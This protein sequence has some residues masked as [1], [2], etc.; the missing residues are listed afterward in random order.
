MAKKMGCC[1][2]QIH[3]RIIAIIC[4]LLTAIS[5]LNI[6]KLIFIEYFGYTLNIFSY[7]VHDD[8]VLAIV[9]QIFIFMAHLITYVMCF[10]AA[11]R[12][13]K[14]MLIPFLIVTLLH[15]LFYI[16]LGIWVIYIGLVEVLKIIEFTKN[17]DFFGLGIL[18]FILFI[19]ILAALVISIYFLIVVAKF[20]HQIDSINPPTIIIHH[21]D[22]PQQPSEGEGEV[23]TISAPDVTPSGPITPT[24]LENVC[25]T[26]ITI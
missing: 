14:L 19:P 8:N 5:A 1:S 20:Y 18:A 4:L 17:N 16:G 11:N 25:N 7:D 3:V 10:I 21:C 24:T 26:N 2:L 22:K 12:R 15:I 9:V 6:I 23:A 13:N